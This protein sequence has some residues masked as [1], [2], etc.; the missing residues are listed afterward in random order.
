MKRNSAPSTA[1][2]WSMCVQG[3]SFPRATFWRQFPDRTM[4]R[5]WQVEG[6][7]TNALT[8]IPKSGSSADAPQVV[9]LITT[10]KPG[11]MVK[12]CPILLTGRCDNTSL[13]FFSPSRC[14]FDVASS[15]IALNKPPPNGTPWRSG[16]FVS[17]EIF[18]RVVLPSESV[19][20]R[21]T[22]REVLQPRYRI[23]VF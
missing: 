22:I 3:P 9:G 20:N 16:D 7:A 19:V 21:I 15:L 5:M 23:V 1:H 17:E 4:C 6:V 8:L 18:E 2:E 14:Q 11:A 12:V 10:A 13:F